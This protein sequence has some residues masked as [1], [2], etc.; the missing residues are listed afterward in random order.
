M[1]KVRWE[2]LIALKLKN[3]NVD[4]SSVAENVAAMPNPGD[5]LPFPSYEYFPRPCSQ[6]NS[7]PQS[8]QPPQDSIP[9]YQDQIPQHQNKIV[10]GPSSIKTTPLYQYN[11]MSPQDQQDN[12]EVGVS[13]SSGC[14]CDPEVFDELLHHMHA[15]YTQYH[16]GMMKLFDTFKTKAACASSVNRESSSSPSLP[17]FDVTLCADRN[18]LNAHPELIQL[19]QQA[20]LANGQNRAPAVSGPTAGF[21]SYADYAKMVQNVNANYNTVVSSSQDDSVVGAAPVQQ[22]HDEERE[23]IMSQLKTHMAN[24]PEPIIVQPAEEP[25]VAAA[26]PE[27]PSKTPIHFRIK[28]LLDNLKNNWKLRLA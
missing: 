9:S 21:L 3:S 18:N 25:V 26:V 22:N 11:L 2:V 7:I 14:K 4:D 10:I 23:Q 27:T 13:I 28:S 6:S 8:Y 20:Y 19:C 5:Y 24:N 12:Q 16:N 1:C 17:V 15:G